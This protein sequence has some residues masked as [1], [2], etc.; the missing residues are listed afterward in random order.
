MVEL[1]QNVNWM[2]VIVG[3]LLAF[4]ASWAWYSPKLFGKRWAQGLAID[5]AGAPPVAAMMLQ[6]L[7]LFLLSWFVAVTAAPGALMTLL[8]GA[9]AFVVL[10]YSGE[11]FGG[12]TPAVRLING[13]YWALAV[14]VMILTN[15]AF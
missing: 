2:A 7:G 5:L 14:V 3:V 9:L 6:G 15:A 1:T 4:F 12:H 13:G 11:S 10:G 8:L